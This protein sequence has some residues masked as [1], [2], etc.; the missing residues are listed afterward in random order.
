MNSAIRARNLKFASL[1]A[2]AT[3][4][5]P[6]LLQ[7]AR[8]QSSSAIS[9]P[10]SGSVDYDGSHYVFSGSALLEMKDGKIV[11][12]IVKMPNHDPMPQ[13]GIDVERAKRAVAKY[14]AEKNEPPSQGDSGPAGSPGFNSAA[15]P[16]TSQKPP[17]TAPTF[18][19]GDDRQSYTVLFPEGVSVRVSD[20]GKQVELRGLIDMPGIPADKAPPLTLVYDGTGSQLKNLVLAG[21]QGHQRAA[22]AITGVGAWHTIQNN[23]RNPN[24]EIGGYE[25]DNPFAASAGSP[26][27]MIFG[28]ANFCV[29]AFD[30]A[31]EHGVKV[32][33]KTAMKTIVAQGKTFG[34][35]DR[36]SRQVKTPQSQL[37]Q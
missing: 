4:F 34:T 10:A 25:Q 3:L 8:G 33:G 1:L 16:V 15:S 6:L 35:N 2:V 20:K 26:P 13:Y 11:G 32:E 12:A 9:I 7:T 29:I 21:N 28:A 27:S 30:I 31:E 19:P 5:I 14:N 17:V 23:T 18:T 37:T 22:D 24:A 36:Y